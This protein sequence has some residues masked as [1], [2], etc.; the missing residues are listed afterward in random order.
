MRHS[1]HFRCATL[2]ALVLIF[3][4]SSL[5]AE[6]QYEA[7]WDS[8]RAHQPAPEW[9]RDAKFGIYFHWGVYSVPAYGNE[10]Y[11]RHMHDKDG[12]RAK[13]VYEHHVHTYGDP[14]EYGYDRFVPQFTAEHFDAEQWVDLFEKAGA[15]FAG[16]V[17]EHH[18]GFAMWDSELTPWNSMDRG[19]K[20][21]IMGEIAA[22]ARKRDM[23]V[24]ATFHHARNNLWEHEEKGKMQ[25]TGHFS[26]AKEHFPSVLEDQERATLYGYIPRD[27]FLNMW[28][29][30][31]D[32][33]IDKYSPD[34]I[35]FDSWL[36]EIPEQTRM[37]FLANYFN[38]A[39]ANGQ[40]VLITYKQKDMPQDI[41]VL[42]LEK[43]GMADLTDFVWLTDDTISL[44][45]WCY[46]NKLKIKPTKVVL[47]SLID[48]VS[49]NG[50]LLLNISPKADGSI[51]ENQREV[52]LGLGAWLESYGEAIYNTRPFTM[53]GHGPT[54]AGKGHFGGIALDKGY[55]SKDIRY[56]QNGDTVY[57]LQ[58]GA[59][60]SN[61][62]VLLKAF[63]QHENASVP[64]VKSVEMLGSQEAIAWN[65]D[66][67]GVS[68]T[69]PASSPDSMAVVYK[70]EL[71]K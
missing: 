47:H 4:A 12:N 55:T 31:L 11:P 19:P 20:R 7:N 54:T 50:Q 6:E 33:V 41:C 53:F 34:L 27:E 39:R 60:A 59:P 13:H 28:L 3:F 24:V 37:Q 30:K 21:D 2:V 40:E 38:H 14:S 42:D 5:H 35:W 48:I 51:P 64:K 9:F 25:W 58:L 8:L 62:K 17:A 18:D 71:E 32:E 63:A 57:A 70:L 26:Y 69:A 22:A 61:E 56:T 36:H 44:G 49:K 15:K 29:G 45:S 46:T 23:K 52:L 43:G 67:A 10:W 1:N 68:I 66:S 16:P 65:Q